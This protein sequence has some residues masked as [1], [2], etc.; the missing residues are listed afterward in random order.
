MGPRTR[1]GQRPSFGA[2]TFARR[3][4]QRHQ[5]ITG[6]LVCGMAIAILSLHHF[7]FSMALAITAATVAVCLVTRLRPIVSVYVVSAVL[8]ASLVWAPN[9]VTFQ[10]MGFDTGLGIDTSQYKTDKAAELYVLE[11][12]HLGNGSVRLK[13]YER[14]AEPTVSQPKL[15]R[16]WSTLPRQTDIPETFDL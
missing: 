6:A 9:G 5:A 11:S 16:G 12:P 8:F 13:M 14:D 2:G 7:G 3:H 4:D 10:P 1:P 15:Q